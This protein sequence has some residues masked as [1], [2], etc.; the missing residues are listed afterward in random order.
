[1]VGQNKKSIQEQETELE[2]YISNSSQSK[3][4]IHVGYISYQALQFKAKLGSFLNDNKIWWMKDLEPSYQQWLVILIKQKKI[5]ATCPAAA[6]S[7]ATTSNVINTT[8]AST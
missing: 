4:D 7:S 3:Q 8:T 1:M 5:W 2:Q 6:A